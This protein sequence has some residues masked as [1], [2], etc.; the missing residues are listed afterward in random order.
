MPVFSEFTKAVDDF[1]LVKYDIRDIE[2]RE[3]DDDFFKFRQRVKELERRLAAVLTQSFDDCDTIIGKFKMLDS[4]EGL[5]NRPIIQD[6]LER[7]QITLLELFK[8][9]LKSTQSIF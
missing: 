1:M 4:F 7:K 9:D 6:E 2:K 3:F 8:Q 5:L